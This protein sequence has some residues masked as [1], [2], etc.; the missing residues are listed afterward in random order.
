[1]QFLILSLAAL[2]A[3]AP[4][5]KARAPLTVCP[6]LDTPLCCQLDVDGVLD[7]TCEARKLP[8]SLLTRVLEFD[9]CKIW[10]SD[11]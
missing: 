6:A 9:R 7:L 11:R 5:L 8:L 10:G 3:A 2:A 1:M 4:S